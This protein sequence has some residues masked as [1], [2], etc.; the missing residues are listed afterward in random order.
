MGLRQRKYLL[1]W[2]VAG[3]ACSCAVASAQDGSNVLVAVEATSRMS[4]RIAAHY[5]RARRI[6]AENVV[7]LK[8]AA[9][10]EVTRAQY[11][12]QIEGPIAA[13]IRRHA[14]HDR[15]FYIVLTKGMPL[16]ISGSGGRGGASASVD[17]ELALLYRKLV[18][19]HIPIVGPL[20][21]PYYESVAAP[22]P[23]ADCSRM[24]IRTSIL[25]RAWTDSPRRTRLPLSTGAPP[26]YPTEISCSDSKGEE[27]QQKLLN[28]G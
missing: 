22:R 7:A 18:G 5:V 17:S 2:F 3:L 26:R 11:E 28:S 1:G 23:I 9:T 14:M 8:T 16:R 25:S 13:W 21:N 10:D 20:P 27:A 19:T 12:E 15:I 4:E 6:P 24:P